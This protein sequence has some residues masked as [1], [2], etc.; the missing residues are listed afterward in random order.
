MK[1][2]KDLALKIATIVSLG[3]FGGFIA[4]GTAE[5]T[6]D[7]EEPK[8]KSDTAKMLDNIQ[9][10]IDEIQLMLIDKRS[11]QLIED[12]KTVNTDI[13]AKIIINELA[14]L[15]NKYNEITNNNENNLT[16]RRTIR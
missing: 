7:L 3:A 13:E 8:A 6:K 11:K 12:L 15:Y 10:N 1:N 2:Y 5:K 14:E 9:E 4:L 16:L